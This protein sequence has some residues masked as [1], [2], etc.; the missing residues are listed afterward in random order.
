MHQ[1]AYPT[2][3]LSVGG[4]HRWQGHQVRVTL[5]NGNHYFFDVPSD[6]AARTEDSVELACH[7]SHKYTA[8]FNRF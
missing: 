8:D 4:P 7:M 2:M 3:T 1:S 6:F 5:R